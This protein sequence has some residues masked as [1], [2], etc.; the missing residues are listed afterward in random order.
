MIKIEK[1]KY[2]KNDF[3]KITTDKTY[4]FHPKMIKGL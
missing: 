1:V 4:N 3:I 2:I